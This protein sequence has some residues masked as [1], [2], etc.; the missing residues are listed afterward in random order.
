MDSVRKRGWIGWA[1]LRKPWI[2]RTS[3]DWRGR[4]PAEGREKGLGLRGERRA[5]RGR[6]VC[7][8]RWRRRAG[9]ISREGSCCGLRGWR[10]PVRPWC[11]G[12]RSGAWRVQSAATGSA[13]QS[14][15]AAGGLASALQWKRRYP[16]RRR[17]S[18]RAS[19]DFLE[20]PGSRAMSSAVAFLM[21]ATLPNFSKRSFFLL[22]EMPGQSSRR[23][24]FMRRR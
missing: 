13:I 11:R 5:A 2:Y 22:G 24:S 1:R 14:G 7:R 9:G 21:R 8:R 18:R 3:R 6:R 12:R 19:A 4:G 20:M 10:C 17:N 15:V 16:P 23:L